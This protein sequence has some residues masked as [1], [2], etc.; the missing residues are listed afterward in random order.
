MVRE[1]RE[2]WNQEE[3]GQRRRTHEL[4]T[5]QQRNGAPEQ[6]PQQRGSKQ[7]G[8]EAA[9]R[10]TGN[11]PESLQFFQ[12]GARQQNGSAQGGVETVIEGSG[13][14]SEEDLS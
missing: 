6:A 1:E 7:L 4:K 12:H 9:D 2:N 10:V 8:L 3:M 13:F 11:E 14:S 5:H